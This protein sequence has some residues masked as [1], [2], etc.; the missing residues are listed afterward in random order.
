[1]HTLRISRSLAAA[2]SALES[3]RSSFGHHHSTRSAKA[4]IISRPFPCW[5]CRVCGNVRPFQRAGHH[6]NGGCVSAATFLFS[7]QPAPAVCSTSFPYLLTELNTP[8][9]ARPAL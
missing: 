8:C 4:P 7:D 1:Y 9:A 5:R 3:D 2:R 6:A